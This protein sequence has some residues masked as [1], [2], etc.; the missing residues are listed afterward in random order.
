MTAMEY[1]ADVVR[2]IRDVALRHVPEDSPDEQYIRVMCDHLIWA[3]KDIGEHGWRAR[4][5]VK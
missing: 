3:L 2:R 5:T 1:H 4:V